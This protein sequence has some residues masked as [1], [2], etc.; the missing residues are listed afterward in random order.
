MAM[1]TWIISFKL[2]D[3]VFR[4]LPLLHGISAPYLAVGVN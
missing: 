1:Q 2:L 3:I 4:R